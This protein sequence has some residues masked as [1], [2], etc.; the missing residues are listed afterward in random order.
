MCE[1]ENFTINDF[2]KKLIIISKN[3][4][5]LSEIVET[6]DENLDAK[7]TAPK[8]NNEEKEKM[9]R[10]FEKHQIGRPSSRYDDKMQKYC[11]MLNKGQIN[12]K[13]KELTLEGDKIFQEGDKY[14][15]MEN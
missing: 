13:P 4:K 2:M 10:I 5:A 14:V 7:Q 9:D 3:V 8:N 1:S 15:F 11:D 6:I 12:K